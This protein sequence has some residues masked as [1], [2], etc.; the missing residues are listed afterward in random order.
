MKTY[1]LGQYTTVFQA[2]VY[3]INAR[4]TE[5][6]D[7]NYKNR[8]IYILSDRQAA[9][10]ALGK[11]QITS[12]LVWDC[13]HSLIQLATHNRVQLIWVPGHKG[14][15]GNDMANQLARMG[16]EHPFIGLEPAC[17]I[18]IGVAMKAVKRLDEQKSQETPGIHNWT[19]TGKG[20]YTR[21]ICQKNEVS[22]EIKQDQLRWV[23][24][25]FTG[26]LSP[27]RT[28]FQTGTNR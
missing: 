22:V 6:I 15:V 9:I 8:H 25:L 11:Y 12:K 18:S 23:V 28:P 2:E 13:H 5:N 26:H 14:I 10:K 24:G 7:W 17:G 3:A 27:K 21:T 19:R 1:S 4:A 20:T 16:S